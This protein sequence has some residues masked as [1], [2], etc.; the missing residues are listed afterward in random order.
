MWQ[1]QVINLLGAT[2]IKDLR[3]D[4]DASLQLPQ[5]DSDPIPFIDGEFFLA[6]KAAAYA[7]AS[8]DRVVRAATLHDIAD[9]KLSKIIRANVKNQQNQPV[10][11][12]PY[13]R[14]SHMIIGR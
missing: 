1:G 13:R 3:L 7:A 12:R 2:Q 9:S 14:N 11:R 10:R 4:Y 6:P 5:S 8:I